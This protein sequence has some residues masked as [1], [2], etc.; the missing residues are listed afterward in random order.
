MTDYDFPLDQQICGMAALDHLEFSRHTA[1]G[2]IL[3][4]KHAHV[5]GRHASIRYCER[6]GIPVRL[7]NLAKRL[8]ALQKVR[9]IV[10]F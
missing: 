3:A 10:G 4:A 5:W 6:R 2:A 9:K 7:F 8:E 1:Q